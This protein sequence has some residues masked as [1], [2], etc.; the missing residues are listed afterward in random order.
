MGI[1]KTRL[2]VCGF[3]CW[4]NMNADIIETVKHCPTS[5]D[6]WQTQPKDKTVPHKIPGRPKECVGADIITINNKQY[7]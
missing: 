1:E 4:V 6:F 3:I 5:L 2:L 7:L